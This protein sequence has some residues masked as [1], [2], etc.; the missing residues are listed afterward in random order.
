[1]QDYLQ[2]K[3]EWKGPIE[4]EVQCLLGKLTLIHLLEI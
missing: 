1:M 4:K 2:D 3:S